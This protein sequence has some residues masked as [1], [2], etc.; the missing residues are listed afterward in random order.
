MSFFKGDERKAN[1]TCERFNISANKLKR[2][3]TRVMQKLTISA[4]SGAYGDDIM[5]LVKR[6]SFCK[7]GGTGITDAEKEETLLIFQN[8]DITDDNE[9]ELNSIVEVSFDENEVATDDYNFDDD[10]KDYGV[11]IPTF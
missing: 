5:S 7:G 8:E 11:E 1:E 3:Q 9:E 2:M 4:K 10:E 6:L